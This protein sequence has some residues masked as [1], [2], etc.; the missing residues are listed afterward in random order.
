MQMQNSYIR[1]LNYEKTT[2]LSLVQGDKS[3]IRLQLLDKSQKLIDSLN[4]KTAEISII[5]TSNN[6]L[7]EFITTVVEDGVVTFNL[8]SV[9]AIGEHQVRIKVE[10]Y[11]FPSS[12]S[13]FSLVILPA[14]D[15]NTEIIPTEIETINIVVEKMTADVVEQVSVNAIDYIV[16]NKADFKGEKGDTVAA[17]PKVFTRA[18]YDALPTKSADTLYIVKEVE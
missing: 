15:I 16:N 11:Y 8:N 5:E 12:S 17:P 10:D 18:E 9:L 13:T 2:S 7:R 6:T 1:M 4:T 14:H 3:K